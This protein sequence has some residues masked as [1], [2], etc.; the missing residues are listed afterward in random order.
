M[1]CTISSNGGWKYGLGSVSHAHDVIT[2][3]FMLKGIQVNLSLP[4]FP[5]VPELDWNHIASLT[6]ITKVKLPQLDELLEVN[7]L[8]KH[9]NY[10]A[11]IA[12]GVCVLIIIVVTGLV[13][14]RYQ[15][16]I[17]K[18][19]RRR[20]RPGQTG[21]PDIPLQELQT[22][23]NTGPEA[24]AIPLLVRTTIPETTE[25]V[26]T[27]PPADTT[28]IKGQ[29]QQVQPLYPKLTFSTPLTRATT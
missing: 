12:T 17:G 24:A 21:I 2:D 15:G 11:W 19:C 6:G 28:E 3:E 27:A 10:V 4:V 9:D 16:R 5:T 13:C 29:I 7:Y 8:T 18:C 20:E 23:S 1:N 14:R 26:P 25:E 22:S